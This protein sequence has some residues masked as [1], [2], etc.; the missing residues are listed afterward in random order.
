MKDFNVVD[1]ISEKIILNTEKIHRPQDKFFRKLKKTEF[2][3][4]LPKDKNLR[5]TF[6]RNTYEVKLDH[7]LT[8]ED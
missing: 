3:K 2:K 4:R 1:N 6:K 5:F 8:R 7:V